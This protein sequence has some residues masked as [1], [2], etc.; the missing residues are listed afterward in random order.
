MKIDKVEVFF[1]PVA[2]DKNVS[3][4]TWRLETMGYAVV[5]LST[6]DGI[7]G[8]G[9]TYDVAG[10]AI[11]EVITRNLASVVLGRDPFAT[12]VIWTDAMNLL[13][14]AGRKG[15]VLIALSIVDIALWDI[16]AK[17]AGMPLYQLLGGSE[18]TIPIYGS[19]GWTSYT[20]KELIEEIEQIKDQGYTKIK[21]KVGVD[22]G[23][24][25]EEDV[26]RVRSV[27]KHIGEKID[28]MIDANN[29]WDASTAIKVAKKLSDCNLFFFEEP[30]M[31]DDI[32]GLAN[33]KSKITIPVAT[34]EQE[35]TKYGARDLIINNAVDILQM[36]ATK[37]GGITEWLK[38]AALAQ[39]WNIPFAPHA[40]HYLHMHL[41]SAAPNG[42][43]LENLF[44]H[45]KVNELLMVD[46]PKPK[47][48][49]LEIP[50]KPGIG[51][52]FNEENLHKYN[53][54]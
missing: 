21:M 8:I 48:G 22:L 34:G 45:E 5:R 10:E 49:F 2:P 25:P 1:V 14:G 30:V 17:A 36:D 46:P 40:M 19:G 27:R 15:L 38:I 4:S 24:S 42:L 3:D 13:R 39:A 35:Y 20:E 32:L 41:V 12:E 43:I 26:R 47:N 11:R 53:I 6:D 16:K 52:D 50:D 54:S 28:L 51:I 33:V 29:A 18:R 31:A 37:C 9:Y 23:K 44:M 7:S